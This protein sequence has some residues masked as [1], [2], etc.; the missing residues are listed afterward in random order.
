MTP[1]EV[2]A[3]LGVPVV[4]VEIDGADLLAKIFSE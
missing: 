4:P 1:T 3:A 2:S